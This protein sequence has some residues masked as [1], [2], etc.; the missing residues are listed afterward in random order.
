MTNTSR[1]FWELKAEQVM[2]RV[3]AGTQT[4][5]DPA[6][7]APGVASTATTTA[8]RPDDT[9]EVEV[10]ETRSRRPLPRQA[11]LALAVL[12]GAGLVSSLGFWRGWHQASH[13][14]HQERTIRLLEGIRGLIGEQPP[15]PA[16]P[17]PTAQGTGLPPP[18][19][20]G[21]EAWI[22]ELGQLNASGPA[23]LGATPLQ[24][25]LSGTLRAPAPAAGEPAGLE[26]AGSDRAPELLGVVQS[27]GKPGSAI[28]QVG[29]S[30]TNAMAGETIGSS[31]W[32]LVSTSGDSAVIQRNGVSRRV[33]ISSGF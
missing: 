2:D 31:G 10:R 17:T 21:Q 33:S 3:F 29:G 28:F 11:V 6:S 27:P 13:A 1:A 30:S 18:P 23:S 9:I 26:P 24:V 20:A 14:L 4:S 5:A 22:E 32:R 7:P 25:P 8:T 19:P 12:A 16:A 15:A